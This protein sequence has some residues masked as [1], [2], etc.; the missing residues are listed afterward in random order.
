MSDFY[1]A[2]FICLQAN[3]RRYKLHLKVKSVLNFINNVFIQ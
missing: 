3:K 1:K 2:A